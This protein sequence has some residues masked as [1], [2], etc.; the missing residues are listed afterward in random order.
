MGTVPLS[1]LFQLDVGNVNSPS[2]G[3]GVGGQAGSSVAAAGAGGTNRSESSSPTS[4][5]KREQHRARASVSGIEDAESLAINTSV[6]LGSQQVWPMK[7]LFNLLFAFCKTHPQSSP[8]S[9]K[10][11]YVYWT[12]NSSHWQ[13]VSVNGRRNFKLNKPV[14]HWNFWNLSL[15][16]VGL[17]FQYLDSVFKQ[18]K[19]LKVRISF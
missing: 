19:P 12:V 10:W 3:A 11:N 4:T 6:T 15:I 9:T 18:N 14:K 16:F 8:E 13:E 5:L 1:E 2:K 17:P 7:R